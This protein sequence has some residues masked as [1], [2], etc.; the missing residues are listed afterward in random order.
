MISD[1]RSSI[2]Q[3]G[4]ADWVTVAGYLISAALSVRA[5]RHAEADSRDSLFWRFTAIL[6]V[7]FGINEL[8]DLQTLVT[9]VGRAHAM[10]NGWYDN[11]RSVQFA[12]VVALG[13]AAVLAGVALIRLTWRSH[14]SVRLALAGLTFIGLFVLLRAASFHH[15]SAIFDRGVPGLNWGSL[16]E[17]VGI[18]M[19]GVAAELCTRKDRRHST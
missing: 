16:Q 1:W 12:F 6:L 7:L 15:V 19:V 13:V 14:A 18:L 10:T 2:A 5:A 3:A 9:S 8:L 17:M 11:R 4:F